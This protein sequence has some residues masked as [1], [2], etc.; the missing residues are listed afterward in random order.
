LSGALLD[1]L[2]VAIPPSIASSLLSPL[3]LLES[4]VGAFTATG[5]DLTM[6]AL[7]LIVGVLW[8][9]GRRRRRPRPILDKAIAEIQQ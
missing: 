8:T 3:L 2:E 4:T 6:P 5:R 9:E 7:L 1:G